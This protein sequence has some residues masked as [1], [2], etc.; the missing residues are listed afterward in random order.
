MPMTPEADRDRP[1]L[2]HWT[3]KRSS[4]ILGVAWIVLLALLYLSPALKD[5]PTFGP[6]DIGSSV[7]FLTSSRVHSIHDVVN[8]DVIDEAVAWNTLDWQLVH[9]GELPLWNGLSG[10]GMPLLLNFQ[11]AALALPTLMGYLFPL[12][13]A[14][15]VTVAMKML[16]AGT[17]AYVLTRLLGGR[18]LAGAL[19]GTTFMLS[20]S[21]AGWLGWSTSGPLAWMGWLAA[22]CILTYRARRGR[23]ARAVALLSLCVAFCV[24]GGSPD[25][26]A[27]VAIGLAVL[28]VVTG[29]ATL[30]ARRPIDLPG[31]ARLG[32]GAVGGLALSSPLWL[33]G[34]AVLRQSVFSGTVVARGLP[35]RSALLLFAP[36]YDG[37]PIG[38]PHAPLGSYYGPLDYFE[39]AAYV[40]IVAIA[41]A[42]LALARHW[43]RPVVA[44]LGATALVT[45]L[46]VYDLGAGAPVQHLVQHLGLKP[47]ALQRMLPVLA[48]A[49][50]VLAGLGL[51]L[52]LRRWRDSAT[53]L[54]FIVSVSI[55]CVVLAAMWVKSGSPG[56]V[57]QGG[58]LP[59]VSTAS[60]RR[61]ALLWPTVE[62][63]ALLALASTLPLA[64]RWAKTGRPPARRRFVSVT[65][66]CVVLV[67]AQGC[68]LV[69]AGAGINSYAS[70]SYP[71][72]PAVA[73]LQRIVGDR[74]LGLDVHSLDCTTTPP[75]VLC[76]VRTW[77]GVG[78][79]PEI[80]LGYGIAELAVYDPLLPTAYVHGW[81]VKAQEASGPNLFVPSI[82]SLA[83]ARRYGVQYV[84]IQ[85]PR[86]V[87]AGM[88][89]VATIRGA[90][91]K[92]LKLARVPGASRFSFSPAPT[93]GAGPDGARVISVSHPADDTYRLQVHVEQTQRLVIRI[94]DVPG[95]HATADGHPLALVRAAAGL[96]SAMVPGGTTRVVVSYRPALFDVGTVVAVAVLVLLVGAPTAAWLWR[97]KRTLA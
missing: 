77:E 88:H 89:L 15:L 11:S 65:S 61:S 66:A 25:A 2:R 95:W 24:L 41:F 40:G 35:L 86:P 93:T 60:L 46:L 80:N 81:P 79:Y 14:F 6:A 17:G 69:V 73:A 26:Y 44:A 82:D 91:H 21:F 85:P 42:G 62:A 1:R 30:A 18:P 27:L 57:G 19:A 23:R 97:R 67:A 56:L 84:L 72:T 76:G 10:N 74:L 58:R 53:Q 78:F 31:T 47:V 7:S 50:G 3:K 36:G 55:V 38:S 51:E 94:T 48:L 32:A 54:V 43:R 52:L 34:I 20:G 71:V 59:P 70:T 9:H 13:L 45:L 5:G 49:V 75:S 37:L 63:L 96:Q 90:D 29:L 92:L 28:L 33:P 87:P 4:D 16:I 8:G 68:L 22:A 12:S 39:T 83:L 64:S